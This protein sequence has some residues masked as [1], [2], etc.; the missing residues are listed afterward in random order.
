[1]LLGPALVVLSPWLVFS[2]G[3]LR[4]RV[5]NE[6]SAMS[7]T[8]ECVSFSE[9]RES[10]ALGW[11]SALVAFGVIALFLGLWLFRSSR[12]YRIEL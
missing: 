12:A 10:A 7:T 3:P 2:F 1:M 8:G 4:D 6:G 5:Y 11:L 9:L